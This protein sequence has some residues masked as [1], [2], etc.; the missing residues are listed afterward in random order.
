MLYRLMF[1]DTCAV[2]AVTAIKQ[3]YNHVVQTDI[4]LCAALA[5]TGIRYD[6]NHAV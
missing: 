3:D 1:Y 2:L 6:Y 5:M 4:L